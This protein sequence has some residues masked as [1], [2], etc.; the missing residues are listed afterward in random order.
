MTFK[1]TFNFTACRVSAIDISDDVDGLV[2]IA[3]KATLVR[4]PDT[5]QI[6]IFKAGHGR[7]KDASDRFQ[8][9]ARAL[10]VRNQPEDSGELLG[11]YFAVKG[12]GK[13]PDDFATLEY[14]AACLKADRERH[15]RAHEYL[16]ECL[17]LEACG[18]LSA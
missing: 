6:F 17:A 10:G 11:R 18:I 3:V 5:E 2:E 4:S 12:G 7:R 1:P 9:L 14:A 16:A 13:K 15:S 8:S